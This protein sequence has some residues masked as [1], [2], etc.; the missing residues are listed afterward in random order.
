MAGAFALLPGYSTDSRWDHGDLWLGLKRAFSRRPT[1]APVSFQKVK[2]HA[3]AQHIAAGVITQAGRYSRLA[4]LT[5]IFVVRPRE[6]NV[7]VCNLYDF[8]VKSDDRQNILMVDGD[9]VVVTRMYPLEHQAYAREWD[10]IAEY[11]AGR[12]TRDGL[13]Q[14]IKNLPP[15]SWKD[16]P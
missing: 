5:Q 9:V 2:A 7:I 3:L 16:E 6:M 10:P 12:L 11:L 15:P 14:A 4:N 1:L 8:N 13:I